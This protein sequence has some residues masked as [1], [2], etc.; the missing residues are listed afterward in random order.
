MSQDNIIDE[1][2]SQASNRRR[3]LRKIGV[4]GA[5]AG[6]ALAAGTL[7]AEAQTSSSSGISANDAAILTFALNLE[8]LEAEFYT[9][10]TTG[11]T[12]DQA[13]GIPIT[14]TGQQGP[15]TGGQRVDLFTT[16]LLPLIQE[17]AADEQAHVKLIRGALTGAGITPIA[18]PA[19]NLNALG[20]GFVDQNDFLQ[21]ARIFEDIGVTAYEGAAGLLQSNALLQTAA[22]ILGTEAEHSGAIR[23]LSAM[24]NLKSPTLD[25]VDVP[26]PPSG[27]NYFSTDANGLVRQR[28]TGQ[29]LYLAYGMQAGVTS[30]GFFPN[31]VNG[32]INQ[33]TASA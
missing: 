3:F 16:G 20:F 29:V 13:V 18:K 19:I 1:L 33:S 32:S 17:V 24:W 15:T 26:P 2:A 8:Y 6:G 30:G 4:A 12:I 31:G 10:A 27:K 28:T 5:L 21:L 22:E 14:G 25:G 9:L 7:P 11:Q 23:T